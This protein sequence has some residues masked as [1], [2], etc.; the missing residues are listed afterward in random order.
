MDVAGV[1]KFWNSIGRMLRALTIRV[2]PV[3]DLK[4][5]FVIVFLL[6]FDLRTMKIYK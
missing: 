2:V 5:L 4:M 3:V 1:V 6:N